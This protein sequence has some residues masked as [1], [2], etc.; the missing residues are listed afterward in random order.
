[1]PSPATAAAKTV[2]AIGDSLTAGL[3]LDAKDAF[4]AQLQAALKAAGH[5]VRVIGAGVSGDTTAGGRTRLNWALAAAGPQGPDAVIVELGAND[6]LRG[7]DPAATHANL[8]AILEALKRRKIAVLLTGMLA[9]PN[10]G[11]EYDAEFRRVFPDLAA[12][13]D[14]L[15]YPF[16]LEGVA[17]DPALNQPD[18]IHPTAQGVAEI[19]RRILPYV[20]KLLDTL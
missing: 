14:V 5:D 17:A 15:F 9:P 3:G 1:M 4:P 6:G 10:L 20:L 7:I 2:V 12:R 19:V 16:F 13:Y 11:R 18:G 8:A